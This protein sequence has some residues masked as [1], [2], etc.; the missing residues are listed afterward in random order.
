MPPP[1]SRHGIPP[2]VGGTG[3]EGDPG[4]G[5]N[6]LGVTGA[7]SPG[8]VLALDLGGTQIR[9]AVVDVDLKG[10]GHKSGNLP[11]SVAE[12]MGLLHAAGLSRFLP[13]FTVATGGGL[14]WHWK[15]REPWFFE[16]GSDPKFHERDRFASILRRVQRLI[17]DTAAA[18][19]LAVDSTCDLERILRPAGTIRVKDGC[20]PVQTRFADELGCGVAYN[21]AEFEELL[22]MLAVPDRQEDHGDAPVEVGAITVNSRAVV[23]QDQVRLMLDADPALSQILNLQKPTGRRA[24]PEDSFSERDLQLANYLAGNA[25]F[26]AQR[27]TDWLIWFR[28]EKAAPDH[29]RAKHLGYYEI[30]ASKALDFARRQREEEERR[31]TVEAKREAAAAEVTNTGEQ[32]ARAMESQDG[33]RAVLKDV[34]KRDIRRM[35]VLKD[36]DEKTYQLEVDG[37]R[38]NIGGVAAIFNADI[39]SRQVWDVTGRP[40]PPVKRKTWTEVVLPA[41][42]TIREE[43]E[44][45]ADHGKI[46]RWLH[47]WL[48]HEPSSQCKNE[49]EW[50]S[51]IERMADSKTFIEQRPGGAVQVYGDS[52]QCVLR[53]NRLSRWMSSIFGQQALGYQTKE[54]ETAIRLRLVAAGFERPK[55][56]VT[57]SIGDRKFKLRDVFVGGA[58]WW[59]QFGESDPETGVGPDAIG[60]ENALIY[61]R[62][63]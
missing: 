39:A 54:T 21:P 2:A 61:R 4:A 5:R 25:N 63:N 58:G 13:T 62:P 9:A 51:A 42:H 14:H 41:L 26:D 32:Q 34:L 11:Q 30:T 6:G 29:K 57:I 22:D 20:P 27:I 3:D 16:A 33:A 1:Q 18:K 23:D 36:N 59:S 8:L 47:D 12:A 28:R 50:L 38:V 15:F 10:P 53:A 52:R 48:T 45:D 19:G 49:R 7:A 60:S 24:A 37:Q 43:V 55:E 17:R 31:R 40:L 56:S 35:L 44:L 46:R